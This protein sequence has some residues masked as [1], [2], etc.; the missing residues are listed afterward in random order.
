MLEIGHNSTT[1]RGSYFTFNTNK[2]RTP[3]AQT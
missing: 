1:G 2:V 3:D